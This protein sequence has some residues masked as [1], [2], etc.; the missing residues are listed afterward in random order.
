MFERPQ[1]GE[2][3]VLIHVAPGGV[4][5]S[6]EREEFAE[7]AV[8]AGAVVVDELVGSRRTPDSRYFIGKGKVE[9]VR[10][11]IADTDAELVI[12]SAARSLCFTTRHTTPSLG[13]GGGSGRRR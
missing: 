5:E 2:R 7:L 11:S 12:S 8:S 9:E 6:N 10:E 13:R 1:I 3:A 4:P